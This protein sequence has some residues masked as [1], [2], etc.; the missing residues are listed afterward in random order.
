SLSTPLGMDAQHPR[1]SWKLNNASDGARQTAYQLQVSSN[2]ALLT[3]GHRNVWDS[4]RVQSDKSIGVVYAGP[5][6]APSKRYYWRVLV[7]G[8]DGKPYP[9]S[10]ASWWETG[11]LE[12][13][14]WKAKWIAYEEPV[15]RAVRESGAAWI[16]NADAEVTA[17]GNTQNDFR[18]EFEVMNSIRESVLYVTGQDTASA[19]LNGKRVVDASPLPASGSRPW[20]KYEMHVVTEEIH[21][22]KNVLAVE[23]TR[24]A[25]HGQQ[26][27]R[28]PSQAPM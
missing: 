3:K 18:F 5:P 7:W 9:A 8:R 20:K 22:G 28:N 19:W 6:L 1:L 27:A 15:E 16:T 24:Y 12:Q 2:T 25:K 26:P 14:N 13:A 11:L 17:D 4:G 10:D 21:K 23:V